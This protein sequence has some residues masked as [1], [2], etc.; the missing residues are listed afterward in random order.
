MN[1]SLLNSTGNDEIDQILI[2]IIK[3]FEKKFYNRIRSYYLLGSYIDGSAVKAS[4]LDVYLLF[5][6]KITTKE[7]YYFD[8]LLKN[9]L[10]FNC[11]DL[12]IVA[13]DEFFLS[14]Y[15]GHGSDVLVR[16]GIINLKLA[17][18]ILYGHDIRENILLP[19]M[20]EYVRFTMHTPYHFIKRARL[21][22]NLRFPLEYPDSNQKYYGYVRNWKSHLDKEGIKLIVSI[23][24]WIS[25]S[26]VAL[27]AKRFIGKKSDFVKIYKET[28][29]DER[30]SFIEE[31]YVNCRN[32][33]EYRIPS[34]DIEDMKLQDLCKRLLEFENYFLEV[35]KDYLIK[36]YGQNNYEE[37][38]DSR[39]R[40]IYL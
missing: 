25:T 14:V 30:F 4:D 23:V 7:R 40:E 35:Y 13:F 5:K 12:D 1:I 24:G 38:A 27:R 26:I 15:K 28:I 39:L 34:N 22:K 10:K 21:N 33:W 2:E 16:E 32:K 20:D 29:N 8:R 9:D 37:L 6:N 19:S 36:E 3:F 31:V 17:S 11:I 18:L